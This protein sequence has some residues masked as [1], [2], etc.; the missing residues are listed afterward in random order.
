MVSYDIYFR[1]ISVAAAADGNDDV[2]LGHTKKN[3]Y[4]QVYAG[5]KVHYLT[6]MLAL[7]G[8]SISLLSVCV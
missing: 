5:R 4:T 2:W 6:G 8:V 7:L 3:S 1:F